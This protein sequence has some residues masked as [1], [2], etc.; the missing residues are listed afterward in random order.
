MYNGE[1]RWCW[2]PLKKL[3]TLAQPEAHATANSIS[4]V[5]VYV[6]S[7]QTLLFQ[8]VEQPISSTSATQD[9][10][11]ARYVKRCS[12]VAPDAASLIERATEFVPKLRLKAVPASVAPNSG[13]GTALS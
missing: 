8:Y 7:P 9:L 6:Q 3:A 4:L 12:V 11:D 1:V 2:R 13:A 10:F 5:L